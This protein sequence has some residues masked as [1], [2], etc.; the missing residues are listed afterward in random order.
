MLDAVPSVFPRKNTPLVIPTV[1]PTSPKLTNPKPVAVADN[2]VPG[3][4]FTSKG[5]HKT[6]VISGTVATSNS[7]TTSPKLNDSTSMQPTEI[8]SKELDDAMGRRELVI[9]SAAIQDDHLVLTVMDSVA[10]HQK[11]DIECVSLA[12]SDDQSQD[13]AAINMDESC[14]G[15]KRRKRRKWNRTAFARPAKG[16][17]KSL[18]VKPEHS[19]DQEPESLSDVGGEH[20]GQ[21]Y[22]EV[23]HEVG[24]LQGTTSDSDSLSQ[25]TLLLSEL[26][27]QPYQV[28]SVEQELLQSIQ[29]VSLRC[30]GD[31]EDVRDASDLH[32]ASP[33]EEFQYN[34]LIPAFLHHH[35]SEES[36]FSNESHNLG[37]GLG[38]SQLSAV[39]QSDG[40]TEDDSLRF[41]LVDLRIDPDMPSSHAPSYLD[42][43]ELAHQLNSSL[44]T[45]GKIPL[46][47][48]DNLSLNEETPSDLRLSD[49]LL[50]TPER[51]SK[52][53]TAKLSVNEK[54]PKQSAEI[55]QYN[56]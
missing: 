51:N 8:D 29:A 30:V 39:S 12:N 34:N 7:T 9:E 6:V 15:T 10:Q 18:S 24:E 38:D 21:T 2:N 19:S 3:P 1:L 52:E 53:E 48:V 56:S 42:I 55:L 5:N 4:S 20:D 43:D 25:V 26:P 14:G 49:S 17:R 13:P 41:E 44:F 27:D 11:I 37:G 47:S 28:A 32:D 54:S 36:L 50:I 45:D 33:D 23:K 46:F 16:K 31:H 40:V 22:I 35:S